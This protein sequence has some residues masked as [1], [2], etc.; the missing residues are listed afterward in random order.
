MVVP[1][2]RTQAPLPDASDL[3]GFEPNVLRVLKSRAA[4]IET[5]QQTYGDAL[6]VTI[7]PSRYLDTDLKDP[8]LSFSEA[9]FAPRSISGWTKLSRHFSR[10]CAAMAELAHL[11]SLKPKQIFYE[12]RDTHL[13]VPQLVSTRGDAL[14]LT[15]A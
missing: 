8:F 3:V 14:E 15:P 5:W 1:L 11:S 6:N 2:Q 10:V 13:I 12:D 9:F 4:E 7:Q